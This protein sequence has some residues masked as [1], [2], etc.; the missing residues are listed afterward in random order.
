[1]AGKVD[2]V[3]VDEIGDMAATIVGQAQA[4]DVVI[5]MGAG[6]IGAVPAQVAEMLQGGRA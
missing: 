2:P 3:F 6:S 4:G 1:M 5:S